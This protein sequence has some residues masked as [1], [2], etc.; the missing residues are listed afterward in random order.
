MESQSGDRLQVIEG[1]LVRMAEG[2]AEAGRDEGGG[3]ASRVEQR[4]AGAEPG[5][6]MSDLQHVDPTEQPAFGQ[7]RLDR[8][9][10]I[11]GEQRAEAAAAKHP[12][13]RRIVDV[14]LRQRAGNVTGR[15][16]QDGE[17]GRRIQLQA[18]AA[19]GLG[20]ASTRLSTGE[21]QKSRVGRVRIVAAGIQHQADPITLEGCHQ[22]CDVILVGMGE[23][24]DVY[25]ALPP[26][27]PL[28]KTT[29]QKI[30]IRSAVDQEGGAGR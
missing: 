11:A 26:W 5:P 22:S 12:D 3:G 18:L 29:Q 28:S 30:G 2:V 19:A 14:T 1:L 17:Y 21:L 9:L 10:G 20:E 13:H 23:D 4:R 27:Q 6:M 24:H 15:G 25:A 7:H 8:R 16:V